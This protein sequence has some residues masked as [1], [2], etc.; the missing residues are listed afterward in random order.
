MRLII[1][2]NFRDGRSMERRDG[3]SIDRR[4]GR[5]IERRGGRSL[6]RRESR[7][8]ASTDRRREDVARNSNATAAIDHN[9]N[10]DRNRNKNLGKLWFT[11]FI[12]HT[13]VTF[14]CFFSN[15]DYGFI[16]HWICYTYVPLPLLSPCYAGPN[17]HEKKDIMSRGNNFLGMDLSDINK[18]I[19]HLS[20][21][22]KHN[23]N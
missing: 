14:R 13:N 8:T 5:S 18:H 3:R 7:P 10:I 9:R 1:D 21:S 22:M 11:L 4:D 23:M 12:N 15:E 16:S 6:D 17:L 2:K 20:S 19:F